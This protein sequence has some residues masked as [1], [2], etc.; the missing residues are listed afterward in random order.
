ME[1][2]ILSALYQSREAYDTIKMYLDEND[3]SD[4]GQI[5]YQKAAHFYDNDNEATTIDKELVLS[6]LEREMPKHFD[7]FKR[8]IEGFGHISVPNLREEIISLK[9]HSTSL[10]LSAALMEG[11]HGKVTDLIDLYQQYSSGVLK[12]EENEVQVF[13]GQ[14]ISDLVA[15]SSSGNLVQVYP[16]S[17]NEH[18]EGGV[19]RQTHIIVFAQPEVGKSLFSINMAVGFCKQGLKV[20]YVGNEDPAPQMMMRFVTRFSQMNK[21]EIIKHP[22]D[23]QAKAVDQGYENLIFVSLPSGTIGEI[24]KYIRTYSPDVIVVDQIRHLNFY[25][26]QGEVEQLT[27]AGKAMRRLGKKYNCVVVSVTQAA[28]SANNK[29]ILDQGDVYMSNTSLPG[30]ADL[31]IGLGMNENFKGQNR[32]MVSPCKN[33]LNGNHEPLPVAIDPTISKVI[34]I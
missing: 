18:L 32:R 28:D 8:T 33:K 23:A 12:E 4:K 21:Y 6:Q 24:E 26:V 3:F 22:A 29:L 20:L 1:K 14:S 7:M 25:G 34:S 30:D 19:P 13:T 2:Q 11:N 16:L 31:L 17:L 5:L 10:D 27:R 9:R 15:E